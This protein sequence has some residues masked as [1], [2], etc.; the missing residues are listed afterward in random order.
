[1]EGGEPVGQNWSPPGDTEVEMLHRLVT[2]GVQA[3]TRKPPCPV[4]GLYNAHCPVS[5]PQ[6]KP[7]KTI[8]GFV[9]TRIGGPQVPTPQEVYTSRFPRRFSP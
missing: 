3:N 1:V 5:V 6:S 7:I 4:L 8:S 9:P 2:G